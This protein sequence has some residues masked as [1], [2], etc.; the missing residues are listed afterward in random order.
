LNK[1]LKSI[2]NQ[3]FK[4][5]EHI[6]IDSYSKDSTIEIISEYQI[7]SKHKICVYSIPPE[8]IS[9][10]MNEGLLKSNGKFIN[11]LHSDDMLYSNTTLKTAY[12]Q[13]IASGALWLYSDMI[14][15][16]E[17]KKDIIYLRSEKFNSQKLLFENYIFHPTNFVDKQ[18]L[19]KSQGFDES[20][21]VA[22]DYDLYFKL[23][24]YTKPIYTP[25]PLII[26]RRHANGISSTKRLLANREKLFIQKINSTGKLKK[27]RFYTIF[28]IN[29]FIIL[30]VIWFK[31]SYLK[32]QYTRNVISYKLNVKYFLRNENLS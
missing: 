25:E 12:D 30:I 26:F 21:K 24:K 2:S 29:S 16:D 32:W 22:M 8:G 11:F 23:Q 14:L 19:R 1:T 31:P 18:I 4:D 28:L 27:L 10:A 3:T 13:I 5:F 20:L 7:K 15:K 9:R 6:I 17:F